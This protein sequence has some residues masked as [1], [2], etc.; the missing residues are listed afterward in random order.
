M[1]NIGDYVEIPGHD[2]TIGPLK[3]IGAAY[4]KES[5]AKDGKP[6]FSETRRNEAAK[7]IRALSPFYSDADVIRPVAGL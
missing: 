3:T 6:T 2:T 7:K 4:V 5:F 1:A